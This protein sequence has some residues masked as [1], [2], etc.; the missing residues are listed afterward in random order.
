M[1]F[2]TGM[3]V[4]G[5]LSKGVMLA[6]VLVVALCMLSPIGVVQAA[7][8]LDSQALAATPPLQH[9]T[10]QLFKNGTVFNEYGQAILVDR[11]ACDF[12]IG[13]IDNDGRTEAVVISSQTN[14][15]QI[16]HQLSNG[17]F[18]GRPERIIR[19]DVID[20]RSVAIGDLNNDGLNDIAVSCNSTGHNPEIAIFYQ[21]N[22]FN[23]SYAKIL[24]LFRPNPSM[25]AIGHFTSKTLNSVAVLCEGSP[26]M[27]DDEI[28]IWSQPMNDDSD[29]SYLPIAGFM[30]SRCMAAADIDGDNLT[31]IVVAEKGA[32]NVG[33]FTHSAGGDWNSQQTMSISGSAA[34]VELCDVN[35]D[36][37][38]DLIFANSINSKIY[39]F[40]NTGTFFSSISQTPIPASG[41]SDVTFGNVTDDG[42]H[43]AVWAS[44]SGSNVSAAFALTSTSWSLT[45]NA[46]VPVNAKPLKIVIDPSAQGTEYLLVL[47]AGDGVSNST[48]EAFSCNSR[49]T[50]NADLNLFTAALS[51]GKLA[52]GR[53]GDGSDIIAS[54]IPGSNEV[55]LSDPTSGLR[56]LL[57]TSVGPVDLVFGN[58]DGDS[59]NDLAILCS[60]SHTVNVYKDEQYALGTQPFV[61]ITIPLTDASCIAN[62]SIRDNGRDDLVIGSGHGLLALYNT[63]TSSM[64]N[65]AQ[66]ETFGSSCVGSTANIV[67]GDFDQDR[68]AT[69]LAVLNSATSTVEIFLRNHPGTAGNYYPKNPSANLTYSGSSMKMMVSGDFGGPTGQDLAILDSTNRILIYDQQPYGFTIDVSAAAVL[70]IKEAA[71]A[72]GAGDINDDGKE[73]LVVGYANTPIVDTYLRNGVSTFQEGPNWTSGGIC[74]DVAACDLNGDLRT[75]VVCSAPDSHSLSLWFQQNLAPKANATASA[76]TA[77]EGQKITFSGEGS[78]DS[79]SDRGSLT[80]QWWFNSTYHPIG[81]IVNATYWEYGPYNVSLKV[82]DRGGLSDWS[83][84]SMVIT[85]TFPVADFNFTPTS[86]RE[87]VDT[88]NFTDLSHSYPHPIN[89]WNWSFGDGNYSNLA[90]PLPH[91]YGNQGN[92]TVNLTVTDSDGGRGNISK[93]IQV[94]DTVPVANFTSS[95]YQISEGQICNFTDHSK[96]IY[97]PIKSWTWSFGDGG[98]GSGNLSSHRYVV[99]GNYTVELTVEDNDGSISRA[100]CNIT[101]ID[102]PPKANFTVS[103][104]SP[105]EGTSVVFNDT[106]SHYDGII[107][108]HWDFGDGTSSKLSNVTHIFAYNRTA[109]YFVTI[110]VTDS[111]NVSSTFGMNI[112]VLYSFPDVSFTYSPENQTEGK[113]VHFVDHSKAYHGLASWYWVFGDN[114]TSHGSQV[115]HTYAKDGNYTVVLTVTDGNGSVNSTSMLVKIVNS[116]PIASFSIEPSQ[117]FEGYHVW[118]NDTSTS[119]DPLHLWKWD[120]GDGST[121]TV[122]NCTHVFVHSGK[123]NVTLLVTDS[124]GSKNTTSQRITIV[125][126]GPTAAFTKTSSTEGQYTYFNDMSTTPSSPIVNWTWNLGDGHVTWSKDVSHIYSTKGEFLVTLTVT[127]DE[128]VSNTTIRWISVAKDET[129]PQVVL[130]GAISSVNTSQAVTVA[131]MV[132]DPVGI[133]SVTLHYLVNNGTENV[134]QMTPQGSPNNYAAQIPGLNHTAIVTYWIVATDNEQNNYSTG[135]YEISVV[136]P[137][138]STLI[139]LF[140]AVVLAAL[141]LSLYMWGS[142]IAVDEVFVIYEDGRLI[143]HQTRRLKPG[144]DDDILSSMLVAIQ[145]FVKDSFKDE[146]A[147][148]LQR[149]DFGDKKILVEKGANVFLAVVLHGERTGKVPD[150]MKEVIAEMEK[151]YGANLVAWDGDLEGVRGIKDTTAPL[152]ATNAALRLPLQGKKSEKLECPACGAK[153]PSDSAKCPQCQAELDNASVEDLEAVAKDLSKGDK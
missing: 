56:R 111:D 46:T 67:P 104:V 52:S 90:N 153:I 115:N 61:N 141:V 135:H 26:T 20:L 86:P 84:L 87:G 2:L 98:V 64:F 22:S 36:G 60:S 71:T 78:N 82:T 80:F 18:S 96:V 76:Y 136:A 24:N 124:D 132:S 1:H 103:S 147:T 129:P 13:D 137:G 105:I 5:Q 59:S 17:L 29:H 101:V 81:E 91:V 15:I 133:D 42:R 142:R 11:G 62:V 144:M 107:S 35:G 109:P 110:T 83:N 70:T 41:V 108:V 97:D 93:K 63:A 45:P 99:H 100:Y 122:E 125:D 116:V 88:V 50:S 9:D 152:L 48:L 7:T 58:F 34:D 112:T 140:V 44:A 128:G 143:A 119:Y 95:A 66:S 12:A 85:Q 77:P 4:M 92:Y 28:D 49:F 23:P 102:V 8:R 53:M 51:P 33:V 120:F 131:A 75:D 31:D 126:K 21:N 10:S 134:V 19:S 6:A 38:P 65:P 74:A 117:G 25:I 3:G 30:K 37:R 151:T 14:A 79:F 127:D 123:Y 113:N 27:A 54:I 72:I 146:S 47:S 43:D 106:S 69:D 73:D 68:N 148:H 145:S 150:K 32:A 114:E 89:L 55:L 149:L 57:S 39:V 138:D 118:F 40:M 130:E 16:Y 121:S 94:M 139:L